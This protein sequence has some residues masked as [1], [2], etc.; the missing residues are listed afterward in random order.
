M[1]AR[2]PPP[3]ISNSLQASRAQRLPTLALLTGTGLAFQT[4]RTQRLVFVA[5]KLL[6]ALQ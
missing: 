5:L 1:W 3:L 2:P 4:D 6:P